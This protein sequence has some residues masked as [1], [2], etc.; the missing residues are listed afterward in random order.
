MI[1]TLSTMTTTITTAQVMNYGIIVV[2]ALIIFLALKEI[3]SAGSNKNK[4][5]QSFVRGSNIAIVPLILIFIAIV[6]YKVITTI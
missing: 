1:S 3:L 2:V 5:M 6:A 4:R